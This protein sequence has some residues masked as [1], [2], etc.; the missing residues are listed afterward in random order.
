MV[1]LRAFD[2]DNTGS[3]GI[4]DIKFSATRIHTN[5]PAEPIWITEMNVNADWGM[6]PHQRPWNEFAAGWWASVYSELAP[7]GVAKLDHYNV[8]ENPQFGLLDYDTGNPYLPYWI[9]KSLNAG[10]PFNCQRLSATS[11]DTEEIETTAARKPN[12]QITVLVAD[13]K[14]D[15]AHPSAGHGLPLD[16]NVVLDGIT[17][18]A[19]TLTQIDLTTPPV[20]GPT[21]VSL[22]PESP[23]A[24]H[25]PGYG[26]ALLTISTD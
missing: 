26:L 24:L 17:P 18:T 11:P 4:P 2:G 25:F 20:T 21:T 13:R 10:F 5:Y 9:V 6:D 23:I 15:P 22:P 3:G 7:L 12:G 19:I 16:V 14:V 8:V 1:L